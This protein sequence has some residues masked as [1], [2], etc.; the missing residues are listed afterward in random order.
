MLAGTHIGRYEIRSKLGEGGMGEVYSALDHELDRNVAIKL[1]PYEFTSDEDRRLRFRKEAKAVSS[2]N[3][4]N[5]ITI[6]EVGENEHGSYLATEFIEGK[7]LRDV[8]KTESLNLSRIL[9]IVEQAAMALAAAHQAGIIHRDIKPENIMIRQDSI[10]KVLDF[11]LAKP[12]YSL[13][14]DVSDENRT[15]PGTVMGSARYMSP[16][17]ARGL[18]VDERTDIWSLGVVLYEMLI[19]AAPF[20]GESTA[21]TI[22]AVV[23]KEPEPLTDL[24]PNLPA[25]LNRI[26]KKSLQKDREERYQSVKDL[27]LDVKG[28][29]YELEHANS[30]DRTKETRKLANFSENPTMIHRTVSS[31]RLT[32][33]NSFADAAPV[34]H[35][36]RWFYGALVVGL[37]LLALL[38]IGTGFLV[39]TSKLSGPEP[40]AATAFIR[41]QI[42]RVNTDGRVLQPAISPDGKYLAYVSGEFGSRSLVVRQVATDSVITLVPPTN[43]NM[44]SISFGPGGDHVYYTLGGSDSSVSTLYQVPAL[45]GVSKR[46]VDDVDGGA[47]FS[48]DGRYFAF[49]R[50]LP[51][52]ND[53]LI[54]VVDTETLE[55]KELKS[56]SASN[57]NFFANRLAWAPDG[58]RLL[59]GAGRR[60]S[61]FVTDTD[62]VE[63]DIK[64]GE[65]RRVN[66]GDFFAVTNFAWLS[67]G[68]G[69]VFTGR[70]SQNDPV[71]IWLA[72]YPGGHIRQITNDPNDYLDLGIAADGRTIVTVKGEVTGSLWRFSPGT[73]NSEQLTADSRSIEGKGGLLQKSDGSIIY[74]RHEGKESVIYLADADGK[75][76]RP[77]F[78]DTGYAVDPALTADGRYVVLNLQK[79]R[80]S[81]IWRMNTDGTNVIPLTEENA[82]V[83]DLSPQITADGS[84]VIFQRQLAG[85]ERFKFM[86]VSVNGGPAEVFYEDEKSG[87]FQPRISPDGKRL[88]FASYDMS[89]F[90]RKI[91][92]ATI[93]GNKFGRLERTV[94]HNLVN[95]FKWSP[96]SKNLTILS[97]RGG[98]QNLWRQPIEGGT[99]TPITDFKAG[100]IFNYQWSFDGKQLMVARGNVNNDLILVRNTNATG[101]N[102]MTR[103]P[104]GAGGSR[105]RA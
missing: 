54:I 82:D 96:D 98:V 18:E 95:G 86:K 30:G 70:T 64:N 42:S 103:R 29:L 51:T 91:N 59:T 66:E 38:F 60:Q 53:D 5:I 63:I 39:Y 79:D 22:A 6:Y 69:F 44:Q 10:V 26:V 57:Y 13:G 21:D 94:E 24:L 17:Q 77:L 47:A 72:S 68:S 36:T 25:E 56:A 3:H 35:R 58:S 37:P 76:P 80:R 73:K 9:R 33:R 48:P 8:L 55:Q 87:I 49:V 46:V 19:G 43:L 27:A 99:A 31:D 71:Q 45:G 81:R 100:R 84:A 1:L 88:A 50:H 102:E 67:D 14:D 85:V 41:P 75:N 101:T 97:N 78:R 105:P 40:L 4:P 32:A 90:T 7:T 89:T 34:K 11:G 16:E 12:K 65:M 15:L 83:L 23:Y 52:S 28:L 2:L 20:D 61:G 74:T 104:Q 93:E 62:V 92:I